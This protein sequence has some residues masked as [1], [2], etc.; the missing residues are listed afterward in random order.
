MMNEDLKM[1]ADIRDAVNACT[2]GVDEAPSLRYRVLQQARGEE[3]PMKKKIT[4]SMILVIALI[5]LSVTAALAAGLGLFGRLAGNEHADERLATLQETAETV[6]QT[7]TTESGVT[8]TIDQAA[9]EGNHIYISYRTEGPGSLHDGLYLED[10]TCLDIIAGDFTEEDGATIGWKECE[11]P[12]D[13]LEETLTFVAKLTE[14]KGEL[15]FTL[16][17]NTQFASLAGSAGLGDCQARAEAKI[18]KVDTMVWV[19]IDYPEEMINQW[20]EGEAELFDY[21]YLYQDGKEVEQVSDM[22]SMSRSAPGQ[23]L[24]EEFFLKLDSCGNLTL[25]PY[26]S[27]EYSAHPEAVMKLETV[28]EGALPTPM[29]HAE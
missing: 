27:D 24:A 4:A 29:P 12:E 20:E 6:E 2:R 22:G 28:A 25:S 5:I 3:E 1:T 11:I 18:G 14:N 13:R 8:I 26:G 7:V 15:P 19:Y 9:Y 21:W 17:R 23:I 16:T 10:G